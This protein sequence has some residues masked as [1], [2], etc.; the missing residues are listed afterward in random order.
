M[1]PGNLKKLPFWVLSG[2]FAGA[3]V[4]KSPQCTKYSGLSKTFAG[5]KFLAQNTQKQFL[6]AALSLPLV[7]EVK[8]G[9]IWSEHTK[10]KNP[11]IVKIPGFCSFCVEKFR[12]ALAE[13]GSATGGFEAVLLLAKN[14]KPVGIPYF[15]GCPNSG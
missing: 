15:F 5:T 10:R 8:S 6:E 9:W 14:E 3:Y 7:N 1:I 11:E 2:S 4:L 13:L 12:S